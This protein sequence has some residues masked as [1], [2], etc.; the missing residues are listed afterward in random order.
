MFWHHITLDRTRQNSRSPRPLRTPSMHTL[1]QHVSL[2]RSFTFKG[3]I[4]SV[5]VTYLP[6]KLHSKQIGPLISLSLLN[7]S[8]PQGRIMYWG[9]LAQLVMLSSSTL[10]EFSILDPDYCFS[11]V[12]LKHFFIRRLG[13]DDVIRKIQWGALRHLTL[14]LHCIV[15]LETWNAMLEI[16]QQLESLELGYLQLSSTVSPDFEPVD[17]NDRAQ[18][19]TAIT[20]GQQYQHQQQARFPHLR[21][22]KLTYLAG[23]SSK[24]CLNLLVAQSP[25]LQSLRWTIRKNRGFPAREFYRLLKAGTWPRLEALEI[26]GYPIHI[27][28]HLLAA[29][30]NVESTRAGK[31]ASFRK[32][33][34]PGSKFGRM[35][36]TALLSP[37]RGHTKTLREL[38]LCCCTQVSGAMAQ[39][40]IA[41]CPRLGAFN[42]GQFITCSCSHHP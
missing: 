36:M 9:F 32:L 16:F 14:S 23:I 38:N 5:F 15:Y 34:V 26:Y 41:G 30:L 4:P 19:E 37:T 12:I 31:Q 3:S 20:L 17:D 28:D 2:I 13:G 7:A 40:I 33:C 22:L 18:L 21:W 39:A 10:K 42:R 35:A 25:S 29:I 8:V 11:Q 24:T 1:D 6:A 27:P